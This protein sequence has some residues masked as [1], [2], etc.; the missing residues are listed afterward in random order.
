MN[1]I[2]IHADIRVFSLR[3]VDLNATRSKCEEVEYIDLNLSLHPLIMFTLSLKMPN[4]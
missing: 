2:Y 4:E 1:D 3:I